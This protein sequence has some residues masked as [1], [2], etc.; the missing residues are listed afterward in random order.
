MYSSVACAVGPSVNKLRT[1]LIFSF[2]TQFLQF[3]FLNFQ[4]QNSL[5]NE[6]LSHLSSENCEINSIKSDSPRAFQQHQECPQIPVQFSVSVLSSFHLKNGSIIN[7]FHTIAPSS[8]KPKS[9]HPYS[10]RT[11]Q[12]Y[13]ECDMKHHGLGDNKTKWNKTNYLPS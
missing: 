12:R 13:Q 4:Q 8:L 2:Q 1:Q 11:F 10:L 6:Y 9:V 5:K 3:F 7:S